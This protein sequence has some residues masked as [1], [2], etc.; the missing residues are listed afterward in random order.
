MFSLESTSCLIQTIPGPQKIQKIKTNKLQD[1]I[2][3]AEQLGL[4][5]C[6][7]QLMS[8]VKSNFSEREVKMIP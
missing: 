6:S 2:V 1:T 3:E 4:N 8:F 7:F 5:G